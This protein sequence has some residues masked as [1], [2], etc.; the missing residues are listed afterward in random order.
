MSSPVEPRS[1]R[2]PH[3]FA[4]VP[5]VRRGPARHSDTA[6]RE[7]LLDPVIYGTCERP[8]DQ[9]GGELASVPA[10]AGV[11]APANEREAGHLEMR[12]S[13]VAAKGRGRPLVPAPPRTP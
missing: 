5:P 10:L 13:L 6:S 7:K 1:P 2:T 4:G 8:L 3:N 12:A 11:V 9:R